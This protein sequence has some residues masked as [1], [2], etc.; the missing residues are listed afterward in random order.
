MGRTHITFDAIARIAAQEPLSQ[1]ATHWRRAAAT[2]TMYIYRPVSRSFQPSVISNDCS[3][4]R[5]G[6]KVSTIDLRTES[7]IMTISRK[8]V[9][10]LV[11]NE[12]SR[13]KPYAININ[14]ML[15]I[16]RQF[17]QSREPMTRDSPF[18]FCRL[19][20]HIQPAISKPPS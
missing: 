8:R 2:Y 3:I 10:D 13:I 7:A 20:R 1:E 6:C 17:Y 12:V 14:L 11:I 9:K 15:T 16:I 4:V 18:I 19:M 5:P